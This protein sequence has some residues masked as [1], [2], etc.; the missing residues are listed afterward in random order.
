MA[1]RDM[2]AEII[3]MCED[4][5]LAIVPWAALGGGRLKTKEQRKKDAA[6]ETAR[7]EKGLRDI[8]IAVSETL[9]KI[10]DAKGTT[11]QA[12]VSLLH[13]V[14]KKLTKISRH[15]QA[16]AYLLQQSTYVFPIVGVQT[17]EHVKAMA[18]SLCIQ[19]TG[20]EMDEIHRV[21]ELEPLFPIPFLFNFRRDRK[22]DLT[23]TPSDQQQYQMGAWIDAPP[24]QPVS[25]RSTSQKLL[26]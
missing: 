8:D 9:E 25:V 17:V 3:P 11:L 5:G 2:E 12:V 13:H 1:F 15:V 22:Y 26:C 23:L 19:L 24:K 4:Q 20:E 6:S 10:A 7:S 21:S 14:S 16:I 18:D